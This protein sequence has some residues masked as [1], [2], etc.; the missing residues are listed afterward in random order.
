MVIKTTIS[1]TTDYKF[2]FHQPEKYA[3][4]AKR[5]LS[6]KIVEEISWHKSEPAWMRDFRLKSLDVYN[7][8]P[9]PTW[10]GNLSDLNFDNIYYYIKPT[11]KK[12]KSW[13]ELPFEIRD[14]YDRIGIPEA[15][16]KYLGGVSAQ[17]ESEV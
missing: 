5:G 1:P 13:E 11:E 10:G 14:T 2:G 6:K 12:A 9:L 17:Y 7:S 4:K 15:E 3:F 8:K 16:K